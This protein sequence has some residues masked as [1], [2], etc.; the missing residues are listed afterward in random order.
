MIKL[1][2]NVNSPLND[3]SARGIS[4]YDP[5]LKRS[6]ALP[7]IITQ[8]EDEYLTPIFSKV[9]NVPKHQT[10]V[11]A[12]LSKMGLSYFD[13]N[14]VVSSKKNLSTNDI[15]S[16][17]NVS[18]EDI[19]T[20]LGLSKDDPLV[21][22]FKEKEDIGGSLTIAGN[23]LYWGLY[24]VGDYNQGAKIVY[25]E[26]FLNNLDLSNPQAIDLLPTAELKTLGDKLVVPCNKSLNI[27]DSRKE[28]RSII[29]SLDTCDEII[30]VADDHAH[31]YIFHNQELIFDDLRLSTYARKVAIMNSAEKYYVFYGQDR[32]EVTVQV[33]DPKNEEVADYSFN[34]F[35]SIENYLTKNKRKFDL[36]H[37]NKIDIKDRAVKN[38]EITPDNR[39][40]FTLKN[41]IVHAKLD[42]D[43][44]NEGT[45]GIKRYFLAKHRIE[46]L[47]S[48]YKEK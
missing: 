4:F 35:D 18:L 17:S 48:Y 23:D 14:E 30:A 44:L 11:V 10:S 9:I 7:H 19:V 22:L 1:L 2:A 31:C 32:G 37:L 6:S 47:T 13:V 36:I 24:K 28:L 45:I 3:L 43:N 33:L 25:F 29:T 41:F 39:V 21:K 12:F 27:G 5:N 34:L 40:F 38:I 16:L 46:S 8:Y 15:G 26:N 20:N 42:L